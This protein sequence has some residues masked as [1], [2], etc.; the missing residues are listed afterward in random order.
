MFMSHGVLASQR[1]LSASHQWVVEL[2]ENSQWCL[3]QRRDAQKVFLLKLASYPES[4]KI[5]PIWLTYL[6]YIG[7]YKSRVNNLKHEDLVK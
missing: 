4:G 1:P 6:E 5:F 3:R 7:G 2:G